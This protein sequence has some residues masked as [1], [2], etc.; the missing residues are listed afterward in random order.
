MIINPY[1]EADYQEDKTVFADCLAKIPN[2][3]T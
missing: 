3:K 1:K 2:I